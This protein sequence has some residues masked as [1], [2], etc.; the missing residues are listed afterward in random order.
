M[1]VASRACGHLQSQ[2]WKLFSLYFANK[3]V[4]ICIGVKIWQAIFYAIQQ[5]ID[6]PFFDFQRVDWITIKF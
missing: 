4:K 5:Y 6:H 1:H 3:T 2:P